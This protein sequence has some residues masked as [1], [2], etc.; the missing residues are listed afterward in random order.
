MSSPAHFRHGHE[1]THAVVM[2][3]AISLTWM[4]EKEEK[5][6]LLLAVSVVE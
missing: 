2:H 1:T 6:I 5:P 3:L 4:Q